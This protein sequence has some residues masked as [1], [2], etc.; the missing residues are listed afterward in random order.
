MYIHHILNE[1]S[2][3][4]HL[5]CFRVSTIVNSAAMN[6]AVHKTIHVIEFLSFLDI[7]PGVGL[8][9]SHGSSVFSFLSYLHAVFHRDH[10]NLRFIWDVLLQQI[11]SR[12]QEPAHTK[13]TPAVTEPQLWV[14]CVIQQIP[15]GYPF[16]IW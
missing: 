13:I 3:K 7:Y 1:S 10:T 6:T 12:T 14:P 4:G 9:E 2:T 11:W 15:T 8:L 5:G 16:Y